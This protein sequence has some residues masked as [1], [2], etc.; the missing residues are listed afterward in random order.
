MLRS[1]FLALFWT[2]PC[3]LI[4]HVVVFCLWCQATLFQRPLLKEALW[5]NVLNPAACAILGVF[6]VRLNAAGGA[7]D[8]HAT[9]VTAAA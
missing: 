7:T 4:L 6:L 1:S 5:T 3:Y 9:L 8:L 2:L